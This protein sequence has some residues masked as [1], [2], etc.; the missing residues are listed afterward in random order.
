VERAGSCSTT[1]NHICI[2]PKERRVRSLLWLDQRCHEGLERLLVAQVIHGNTLSFGLPVLGLA[3]LSSEETLELGNTRLKDI[4]LLNFLSTRL[5]GSSSVASTLQSDSVMFVDHDGG[6]R[7]VALLRTDA[8]NRRWASEDSRRC[9][10]RAALAAVGWSTGVNND[11]VVA[12]V[13]DSTLHRRSRNERLE[14][15]E[16]VGAVAVAAEVE[17]VVEGVVE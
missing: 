6:K 3:C 5:A 9:S 11:R 7:L 17:R 14:L 15:R 4:A 1:I 16:E 2:G 8:S 10:S 12:G 13:G